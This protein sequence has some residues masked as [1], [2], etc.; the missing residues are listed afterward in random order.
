MLPRLTNLT[1][2]VFGFLFPKRCVG[3]G[4]EG[5]FICPSCQNQLFPITPPVCARCGRP[6]SRGSVCSACAAWEASIDG[7]RSVYRFEGVA[8]E[9]VHQLKYSNLRAIAPSLAELIVPYYSSYAIPGD[10]LVPVPLHLKRMRE[11]G[12]NQSALLARE[13]GRL[14]GLVVNEDCLI[15]Q[16]YTTAQARTRNV[17]E[18]RANVGG[19]FACRSR[20]LSGKRVILVDDVATSGATLNACASALKE[21]G[22]LSIWGITFA[23]EI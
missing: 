9:A 8:R 3:C 5:A 17:A 22:V 2:K 13:L 6:L 21:T 14:T 1:G 18:R 16:R 11:R 10:V 4:R 7:I 20:K 15:R 19:A 23:R 12:Y